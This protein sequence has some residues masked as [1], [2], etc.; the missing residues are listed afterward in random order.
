MKVIVG[1]VA[2]VAMA[3]GFILG[4]LAEANA[5]E[6]TTLDDALERPVKVQKYVDKEF[7]VVCY[8]TSRYLKNLSCVQ[9]RGHSAK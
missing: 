3:A 7:G 9:I 1:F 4:C 5:R 2:V 8:W 6:T